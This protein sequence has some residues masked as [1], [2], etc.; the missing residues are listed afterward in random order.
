MK[1]SWRDYYDEGSDEVGALQLRPMR[2]PAGGLRRPGP[3]MIRRP[4]VPVAPRYGEV[5]PGQQG[6]PTGGATSMGFEAAVAFVA[7]GATAGTLR[8]TC[9]E[10]AGFM[11]DR[12]VLERS[13]TGIVDADTLAVIAA[14]PVFVTG[15]N[16]GS[17]NYLANGAGTG[18]IPLARFSANAV[19]P[20]IRGF[21]VAPGITVSVT[22]AC[23][24]L[25]GAGE[26]LIVTGVIEGR[27]L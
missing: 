5:Y 10:P 23:P 22:V 27:A 3:G 14:L 13:Y 2:L 12:I 11:A 9:Q 4:L 8:A 20:G 24:T 25:P 21:F 7:A 19:T 18:L 15:I 26:S 17:S 1:M 6:V 16:V